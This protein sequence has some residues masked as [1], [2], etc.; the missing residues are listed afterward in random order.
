FDYADAHRA[1]MNQFKDYKQLLSFLKKQPLWKK[2]ENYITKKDSIKC[3]TEECNSKP[4]ILNYI[5]AF[6]IRNIIG[7][8]GFYPVFLHDDKTLK[9]AQKLI[10]S[11]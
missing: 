5:Y 8:E 9:K 6:I 10:E 1:Q 11:K 2:F 7:D 3:K 4:L